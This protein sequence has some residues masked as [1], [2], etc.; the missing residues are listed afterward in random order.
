MTLTRP[1]VAAFAALTAVLFAATAVR[2]ADDPAAVIDMPHFCAEQGHTLLRAEPQG[3]AQ[4]YV[5]RKG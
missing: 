1:T 3:D 5:I 2:A 4:L